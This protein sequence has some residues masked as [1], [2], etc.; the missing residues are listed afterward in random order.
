MSSAE[1]EIQMEIK[2]ENAIEY[3]FLGSEGFE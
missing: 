3:S 2:E 1:I